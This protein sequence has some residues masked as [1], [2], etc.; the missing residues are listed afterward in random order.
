M[1]ILN[2]LRKDFLKFRIDL[3]AAFK[4]SAIDQESI[5][6]I[7]ESDTVFIAKYFKIALFDLKNTDLNSCPDIDF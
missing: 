2:F 1:K 7:M 6:A 4:L 3:F 5:W